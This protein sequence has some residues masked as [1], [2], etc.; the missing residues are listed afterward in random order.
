MAIFKRFDQTES[1]ADLAAFL[2]EKYRLNPSRLIDALYMLPFWLSRD[3]N[4]VAGIEASREQLDR[5]AVATA[6]C[7]DT[8]IADD[9]RILE[10]LSGPYAGAK[11]TSALKRVEKLF[12]IFFSSVGSSYKEDRIEL[13]AKLIEHAQPPRWGIRLVVKSS[14]SDQAKRGQENPS[15]DRKEIWGDRGQ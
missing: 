1:D 12:E 14:L 4:D 8:L 11:A 3:G 7:C 9:D 2:R 13:Y 5:L 6:R 10:N 15:R